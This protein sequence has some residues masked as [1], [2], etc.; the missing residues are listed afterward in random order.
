MN[1]NTFEIRIL[2]DLHLGNERFVRSFLGG[3]MRLPESLRLERFD[4][5]EPICRKIEDEGFDAVVD[6]WLNGP[7]AIA[8]KRVSKYKLQ[9]WIQWRREKGL[10]P[11]KYPWGC[12]VSLDRKMP[13]HLVVQ[14]FEFLLYHFQP[15]FAFLTD[16]IDQHVKHFITFRDRNSTM[17]MYKGLDVTE[18]LPGM[19][20]QTYFGPG[21]LDIVDRDKV[22]NLGSDIVRPFGE[23]FIVQPYDRSNLI[24]T[25]EGREREAAILDRLGREHFF[26]KSLVDIESLKRTDEQARRVDEAVARVIAKRQRGETE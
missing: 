10:D 14:F 21:S 1:R 2:T 4:H 7:V 9:L 25:S 5:G 6:A 20:W 24:A 19:Y 26:D 3:W 22:Q 23:G 16:E 15:A 17:E 13:D 12:W 8:F 11:L 18:V